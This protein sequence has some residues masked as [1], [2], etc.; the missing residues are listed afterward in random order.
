MY[1]TFCGAT[2]N[3]ISSPIDAFESLIWTQ[4]WYEAGSFQVVLPISYFPVVQNAVFIYNSDQKNYMV[5]DDI[6]IDSEKNALI[7]SGSSLESMMEWRALTTAF[8]WPDQNVESSARSLV[9]F[10][11][12]SAF[13]ASFAFAN[14]PIT[15]AASHSYA[16]RADI[17]LPEGLLLSDGLR[18]MYEPLGWAYTIKRYSTSNIR[19]DTVI[20]KDRRST[21]SVNPRATFSTTAGDIASYRYNKNKKDYR[22][23][24]FMIAVWGYTPSAPEGVATHSTDLSGA[25]ETKMVYLQ[26]TKSFTT[27]HMEILNKNE[28]SKY[29]IIEAI[30]CKISPASKLIYGT[31]YSIGDYCDVAIRDINM[32]LSAQVTAVDFVYEKGAKFI[33]PTLGRE[34]LNP[35]KYIKREAGK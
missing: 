17:Y 11:C 5:I 35:Q 19:F 21:Q 6:D 9:N 12:T 33:V 15:F 10:M 22:N 25:D 31:D 3:T 34:K 27:D 26:E 29:P 7:V 23:F 30:S 8:N 20:G 13:M 32:T 2:F 14:T 1:I 4:R 18:L 24:A 28:L 16:T